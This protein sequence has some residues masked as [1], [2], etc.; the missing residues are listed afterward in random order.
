MLDAE[1]DV[2]VLIEGA[3]PRHIDVGRLKRNRLVAVGL[4]YLHTAIPHPMIH[5]RHAG[6]EPSLA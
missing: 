3:F 6:R 4:G 2:C 1:S 5:D